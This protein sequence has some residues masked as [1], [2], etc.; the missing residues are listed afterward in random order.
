M[1]TVPTHLNFVSLDGFCMQVNKRLIV[2]EYMPVGILESHSFG[3]FFPKVRLA[4]WSCSS[5]CNAVWYSGYGVDMNLSLL[6]S[7]NV[8]IFCL[9]C[10][11]CL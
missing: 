10:A 5:I 6:L 7:I 11:L 9:F 2:Y 3:E 8:E 4:V 1:L